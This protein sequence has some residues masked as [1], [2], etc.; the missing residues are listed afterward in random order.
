MSLAEHLEVESREL[1]KLVLSKK[2]REKIEGDLVWLEGL[3]A[4]VSGKPPPLEQET[5]VRK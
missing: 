1:K 5:T 3:L 4:F 2:I